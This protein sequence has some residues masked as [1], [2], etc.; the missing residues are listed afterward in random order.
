MWNRGRVLRFSA[1][2]FPLSNPTSALEIAIP[3]PSPPYRLLRLR[4]A[5]SKGTKSLEIVSGVMPTPVSAMAT[6]ML[7]YVSLVVAMVMLPP[8]SVNLM[9][10]RRMFQSTCW[11]RAASV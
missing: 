9:A 8:V 4:S 5:C 3:K 10:L 2:N 11:R 7:S 1:V 6:E